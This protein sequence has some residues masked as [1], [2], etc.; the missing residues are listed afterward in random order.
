MY[1][2]LFVYF[3]LIVLIF[4]SVYLTSQG[5]LK[6]KNL[7]TCCAFTFLGCM[8]SFLTACYYVGIKE[9]LEPVNVSTETLRVIRH[10]T[11]TE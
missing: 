3:A 9:K 8:V 2:L 11:S 7:Y 6:R 5:N 4:L 1:G 10:K